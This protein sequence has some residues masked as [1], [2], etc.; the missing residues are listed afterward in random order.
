MVRDMKGE[1]RATLEEEAKAQVPV[2][3]CGVCASLATAGA[4]REGCADDMWEE[5][6]LLNDQQAWTHIREETAAQR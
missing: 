2:P 5:L 6:S 1:S 4:R 3:A